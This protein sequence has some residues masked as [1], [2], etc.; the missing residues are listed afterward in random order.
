[1]ALVSTIK[2]WFS[3]ELPSYQLLEKYY[4][5]QQQK[6]LQLIVKRYN[7]ALFHFLL[8]QSS[9][10]L[11]EDIL[12]STWLKV[13]KYQGRLKPNTKVKQW[14]FTVARNTLIDELRVQ[15]RWQY[16]ELSDSDVISHDVAKL[17]ETQDRLQ[18]F[19]QAIAQLSYFQREAF[20][21][22]QEGFSLEAISELTQ[23]SFETV[24]SR[25]RYAKKNLQT[26]LGAKHE[27]I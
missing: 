17:W 6:Y 15:Q 26:M 7:Q 1:M 22:Q 9:P 25:L 4:D 2:G 20:I 3:D 27:S 11:A 13:I 10:E 5:T 14:L 24:K 18:V 16:D 8:S 23:E 19:N 21:L 12:Q